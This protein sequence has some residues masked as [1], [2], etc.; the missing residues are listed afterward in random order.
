MRGPCQNSSCT[1]NATKTCVLGNPPDDCE[2]RPILDEGNDKD[3]ENEKD[4][5]DGAVDV[6][7]E[8][9]ASRADAVH[10]GTPVLTEPDDGLR[11]LPAS[12][13]LGVAQVNAITESRPACLVGIVGLAGAGKTAAL[14]SAY[15]LLSNG[16]FKGFS[17]ADSD[18]LRAFEEITR[19]S[20]TW[21]KGN[22]PEQI[23]VHTTLSNDREAGFLHLRLRRD[24]D[25]RIFD[26]LLP[27]LPG[28]WSRLLIDRDDTERF[29]FLG[30]SSV[31]WI[32]VDGR[33]FANAGRVA[34]ARY[35][36]KLLIERLANLLKETRP[37]LIVVPT[38]QDKVAFPQAEAEILLECGRSFG[39]EVDIAPIASFS[40]NDDIVPG[41]GVAELF[42]MTLTAG[43]PP[44]DFWPDTDPASNDRKLASYRRDV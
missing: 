26:M 22:P 39:F 15:L 21:Q 19:A 38:W 3:K 33:Q 12:R 37:H 43:P 16:S 6:E 30:A 25:D 24:E 8:D 10:V 42:N 31:I 32:M 27:D 44:P 28:E 4:A 13:T 23:T 7:D 29:A 5:D 35:R 11:S 14:V 9:D 34:H 18:T 40:W 41:E 1:F 36:A 20:R 2:N 17:Y